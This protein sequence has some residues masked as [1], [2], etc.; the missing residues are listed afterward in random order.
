MTPTI[1]TTATP[2]LPVLDVERFKQ[3]SSHLSEGIETLKLSASTIRVFDD[4]SRDACLEIRNKASERKAKIEAF[5][6]PIAK[7]AF[8]LHRM[9]TGTRGDMTKP[10]ES[11]IATCDKKAAEYTIACR[12]AK[13]AAE[14]QLAA[15]TAQE[16]RS[17][18]E[19]ADELM[20][21]GQ[22]R[23]ARELVAQAAVMQ[24]PVLPDAVSK[25][26]NARMSEP[27]VATVTD[28]MALAKAVVEGRVPATRWVKGE[29]IPLLTV[30]P[31]A[32]KNAADQMGMALRWPGVKVEQEVRFARKGARA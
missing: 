18:Q 7:A 17:L 27:V 4:D 32:L 29:E 14:A 26:S 2:A 19:R 11:I 9:I 1:E 22:V 25:P 6:E 15:S 21:G 13:A 8:G 31:A 10:F 3:A 28:I 30:N 20:A 16:Q 5:W 23:Q 12:Q 24:S